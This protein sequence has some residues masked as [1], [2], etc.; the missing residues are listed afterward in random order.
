MSEKRFEFLDHTADVLIRAYGDTLERAF[1]NAALAVFEVI[2]DTSKVEPKVRVE[3]E[4]EGEDLEQ[5]LYRWIEELLIH[6][7]SEGLVF[8]KFR[9]SISREDTIYRLRGEAWGEVFDPD[10]H[11]HRTVVK[12]MTYAQM[13]IGKLDSTHYVQFVVDI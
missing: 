11:E 4:I 5:L 10:K 13:E 12:A 7:D 3:V 1:E 9:V 2:T 6:H 8:S